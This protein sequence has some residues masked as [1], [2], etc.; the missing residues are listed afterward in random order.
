MFLFCV[1]VY[2]ADFTQLLHWGLKKEENTLS[3]TRLFDKFL[4]KTYQVLLI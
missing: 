2:N 4:L 1:W 3:P